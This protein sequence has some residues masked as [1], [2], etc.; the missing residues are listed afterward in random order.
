MF[1]CGSLRGEKQRV[2][3]HIWKT[4]RHMGVVAACVHSSVDV[5][6]HIELEV[7]DCTEMGLCVCV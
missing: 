6:Q 7:T 2:W 1:R 3:L 4:V 5:V